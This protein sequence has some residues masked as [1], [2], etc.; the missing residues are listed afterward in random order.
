MALGGTDKCPPVEVTVGA[1]VILAVGA[2]VGLT[3]G[4]S[5][6]VSSL[7]GFCS[8]VVVPQGRRFVALVQ[9]C[10]MVEPQAHIW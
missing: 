4:A 6:G 7:S 1:E 2:E 10:R 9:C 3:G 8:I 5:E